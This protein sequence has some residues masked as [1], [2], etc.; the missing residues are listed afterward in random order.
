VRFKGALFLFVIFVLVGGFYFL[1]FL[2]VEKNIKKAE[3]LKKRLFNISTE[4]VDYIRLV[5]N[6]N[7]YELKKKKEGWFITKPETL[8]AD[9]IIIKKMLEKLNKEKIKKLVTMD[10]SRLSEFG[11]KVPAIYALFGYEGNIVE[12]FLGRPNPAATDVYIYRRGMD[13]IF[14]VSKDIVT[15]LN[16]NLFSLRRKEPFLFDP[17]RV[18]GIKIIKDSDTVEMRYSQGKGWIMIT[19]N[20]GRCSEREVIRFLEDIRSVRAEEFY[21]HMQPE[22]ERYPRNAKLVLLNRDGSEV[23]IDLYFWGTSIDTGIVVYQ[24][25]LDY[26][27][28]T[29]REFW[30]R[31]HEDASIFRYRN[32]FE[33]RSDDVVKIEFIDKEDKVVISNKSGQWSYSQKI[34]DKIVIDELLERL[35][36]IEAYRIINK[37]DF[38]RDSVTMRLAISNSDGNR[39]VLNVYDEVDIGKRA[40]SMKAE[41]KTHYA[42]A[43]NLKDPVLITNLQM[44]D[45]KDWIFKAI[46][47]ER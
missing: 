37:R 47:K 32:I 34:L 23:V 18:A 11:L 24:H 3:E 31:I 46:R 5:V 43:S 7:E 25:G 20:M 4:R 8:L 38:D 41:L 16:H 6:G 36:D 21:D 10:M 40:F 14:L 35:A 42:E 9:E 28:R 26:Y 15:V 39:Q 22:P 17:A 33:I 19:P 44:M 1:Y 45:I 30:N 13:G 2:P 27:A 29:G 12:F